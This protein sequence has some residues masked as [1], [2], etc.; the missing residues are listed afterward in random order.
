MSLNPV[1]NLDYPSHE[2][3]FLVRVNENNENIF[4]TDYIAEG[5]VHF[6]GT[7]EGDEYT[8][9]ITRFFHQLMNDP[10]Y[11]NQ[12][13]LLAAGAAVNANRTIIDAQQIKI[14]ILYSEL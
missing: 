13:Y 1:D 10:E 11:T 9:N 8:F 3:L 12:L 6:G 5:E 2:K 4:L 14:T 7:L